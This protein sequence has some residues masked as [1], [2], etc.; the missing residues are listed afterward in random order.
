MI[1]TSLRAKLQSLGHGIEDCSYRDWQGAAYQCSRCEGIFTIP[2]YRPSSLSGVDLRDENDQ[3]F[4]C[5][6]TYFDKHSHF[7]YKY[8]DWTCNE[9]IIMGV[10]K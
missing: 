2:R 5:R 1:T 10:I 8:Q 9:F 7:W 6:I 4:L 3:D